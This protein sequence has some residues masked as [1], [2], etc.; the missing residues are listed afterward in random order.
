[1]IFNADAR[2]E[3]LTPDASQA[4]AKADALDLYRMVFGRTN[5]QHPLNRMLYVDT[6]FYLPN[7]MLVK[8]DRM[9]MANSLEAREP[10]LDYRLVEFAARLPPHLKLNGF[11]HGKYLLKRA[12]HDLLP[13]KTIRR[14]KAGFNV[15]NARWIR[16]GLK[17]F[18]TDQLS[19]DRMR[20]MGLL[21]PAAVNKLL[22]DHFTE[23]AD[24]S[25]QIWG[26]LTL[27]LWWSH[28]IEGALPE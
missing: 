17:P 26:L 1:M 6:R 4:G 15:P 14:K 3:L 10:M 20:R 24:N 2:H 21:Q 25:H 22:K 9:S 28:F 8:V 11:R 7:D 18:V 5:A 13:Q 27:S 16:D 12:M 19:E 23:M